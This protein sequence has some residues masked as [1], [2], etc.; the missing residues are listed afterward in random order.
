MSLACIHGICNGSDPGDFAQGL[1]QRY[2]PIIW[3]P[4]AAK[5]AGKRDPVSDYLVDVFVYRGYWRKVIMDCVESQLWGVR[6]SVVVAHSLG[7]VIIF[8]LILRW[9]ARSQSRPFD[10]CVFLAS[11]LTID[12][13]GRPDIGYRN[14][15]AAAQGLS[16]PPVNAHHFFDV[17]DPVVHGRLW[18]R[19]LKNQF[20]VE[21][22]LKKLGF[23]DRPLEVGFHLLSHVAV[24]RHHD[25]ATHVKGLLNNA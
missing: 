7:T 4:I 3:S 20:T 5:A 23:V 24:W 22:V 13:P 17:D 2:T 9:A 14:R 16:V 1:G 6:P 19:A 8:D 18:G 21:P 15:L 12:V 10:H 25:V 11:P